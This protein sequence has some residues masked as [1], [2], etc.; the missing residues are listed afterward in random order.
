MIVPGIGHD[1]MLDHGWERVAD[2]VIA[3]VRE[4]G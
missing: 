2:Q 4:M 3:W 1:V